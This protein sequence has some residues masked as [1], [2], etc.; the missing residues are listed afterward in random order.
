MA[1]DQNFLALLCD[2]KSTKYPQINQAQA[3]AVQSYLAR[4]VIPD[5]K[6]EKNNSKPLNFE[7]FDILARDD[8]TS[9]YGTYVHKAIEFNTHPEIFKLLLQTCALADPAFFSYAT[10]LQWITAEG[11]GSFAYR[12]IILNNVNPELLLI[13]L[14]VGKY[15]LK[16]LRNFVTSEVDS[17]QQ[18]GQTRLHQAALYGKARL[19][20]ILLELC[21]DTVTELLTLKTDKGFTPVHY[22]VCSGEVDVLN[23]MYSYI[24]KQYQ[25]TR[26][27][28]KAVDADALYEFKPT[29]LVNTTISEKWNSTIK[30]FIKDDNT[31]DLAHSGTHPTRADVKS[32][33]TAHPFTD[34]SLT[35]SSASTSL[36][37]SSSEVSSAS[38]ASSSSTNST[39]STLES[40]STRDTIPAIDPVI[41]Q[42]ADA[43]FLSYLKKHGN[44]H[45][46]VFYVAA[47]RNL[48][49][50]KIDAQKQM[51][52]FS[53]L[54][55]K[56]AAAFDS[57][58]MVSNETGDTPL[59][60]LAKAGDANV[61]LHFLSLFPE[62]TR[63]FLLLKTN[64]NNA[65]P[66]S[67]AARRGYSAIV[68]NCLDILGPYAHVAASIWEKG[69]YAQLSLLHLVCR[70]CDDACVKQVLKLENYDARSDMNLR[71]LFPRG[72]TNLEVISRRVVGD[73]LV[74]AI[75]LLLAVVYGGARR[76][77]C[78]V[79]A[80]L[81]D[82]P[83]LN[84]LYTYRD[85]TAT[86]YL[87]LHF[88]AREG[89][90]ESMELI[91]NAM[92][93]EAALALLTHNISVFGEDTPLS[94]A[95]GN[96]R[97]ALAM[98]A[99]IT[100]L[101]DTLSKSLSQM[102]KAT[103]TLSFQ[104]V[105]R[106]AGTGR[107]HAPI[108]QFSVLSSYSSENTNDNT[109]EA[110]T[111][112][113][114]KWH[115]PSPATSAATSTTGNALTGLLKAGVNAAARLASTATAAVAGNGNG[116]AQEMVDVRLRNNDDDDNDNNNED[117]RANRKR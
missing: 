75:P 88:I 102:P 38:T 104:P 77:R 65:T 112:D 117:K 24:V 39:S 108:S 14:H 81:I 52:M 41:K 13:I 96:S 116:Q 11:L 78:F 67:I 115:V 6:A 86:G 18:P 3:E 111:Y 33:S 68:R 103:A 19:V 49:D 28:D 34:V 71:V 9:G 91:I 37:S 101:I 98:G 25:R 61:F 44:N 10:I 20:E 57:I 51:E 99:K 5:P 22:A 7:P 15:R 2:L 62:S 40:S 94:M 50:D 45:R 42:Q 59:H 79:E 70:F 29:Q 109:V 85:R 36:P 63:P 60:Y 8:V 83:V 84:E 82:W 89:D 100:E 107:T 16:D 97:Y 35:P 92:A 72:L 56:F 17:K 43:T 114:Q 87:P 12:H 46:T 95:R 55:K 80:N 74:G 31:S 4:V 93:P 54:A 106:A 48:L 1:L 113:L 76:V 110:S 30:K 27:F 73:D 23:V 21:E 105:T 26:S 90:P 58:A 69:D 53:Y 47:I 66:V 64:E 32:F